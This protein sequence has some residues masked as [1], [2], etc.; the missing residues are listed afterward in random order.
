MNFIQ[1]TIRFILDKR[2]KTKRKRKQI[3]KTIRKGG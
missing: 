2:K 3:R 1:K